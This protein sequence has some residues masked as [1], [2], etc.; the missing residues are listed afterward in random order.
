MLSQKLGVPA[1]AAAGPP[2]IDRCRDREVARR[3]GHPFEE[4]LPDRLGLLR[5]QPW[6][7]IEIASVLSGPNSTLFAPMRIE[8]VV[9]IEVD[10]RADQ[11][12][13][14]GIGRAVIV[15]AR[16]AEELPA[17]RASGA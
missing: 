14:G 8:E 5:G 10:E 1:I 4:R 7:T 17:A 2:A 11:A 15:A 13:E 12:A 9:A 3:R 6:N 16:A